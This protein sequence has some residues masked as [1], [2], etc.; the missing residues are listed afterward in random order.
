MPTPDD[1]REPALDESRKP[2]F[3]ESRNSP[4]L[5]DADIE[6]RFSGLIGRACRKQLWGSFLDDNQVQQKLLIPIDGLPDLP[7]E[8]GAHKLIRAL[9]EILRMQ[10]A[11]SLILVWERPGGSA[12]LRA[13]LGWVRTLS[14]ACERQSAQLR[15]LLLSH[16][17]GVRCLAR[18]DYRTRDYSL[19]R[20]YG[21]SAQ[22]DTSS[23]QSSSAQGD[24][25]SGQSSSARAGF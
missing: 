10:G 6:E 19:P 21:S 1:M 2:S 7:D 3:Q 13:D 12:L 8:E 20:M 9:S 17:D 16:D 22:G 14:A 4:L 5:T 24:T 11:R 25:S 15:A 23:G 18:V